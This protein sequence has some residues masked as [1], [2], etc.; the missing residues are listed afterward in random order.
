MKRLNSLDWIS[1]ILLIVGG[2]NWGL[3]GLFNFNLV[4]FLFGESSALSR[5][6]YVIVGLAAVYV[7]Y[8]LFR[9]DS[10]I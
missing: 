4:G 3:V 6:I 5:L 7:I 8:F 9:E 2:I 10:E 1:L